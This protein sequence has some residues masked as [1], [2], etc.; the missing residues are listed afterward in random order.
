MKL[1]VWAP[2]CAGMLGGAGPLQVRG[3]RWSLSRE[4]GLGWLPRN[5]GAIRCYRAGW[6]VRRESSNF[7]SS[8]AW[9]KIRPSNG[10]IYWSGSCWI[11]LGT[12][13]RNS[14]CFR[15][16]LDAGDGAAWFNKTTISLF[17]VLILK[18]YSS[19]PASGVVGWGIPPKFFHSTK[20]ELPT[21][22]VAS[23]GSQALRSDC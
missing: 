6:R 12:R 5:R 17:R 2:Q 22:N 14:R 4:V 9:R 13:T 3:S 8:A 21:S 11:R 7:V 16:N 18:A 1:P 10:A 20:L 15:S 23:W 19:A